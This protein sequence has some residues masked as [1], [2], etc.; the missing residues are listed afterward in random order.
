MI[1]V[2]VSHA[3]SH[4]ESE[5]LGLQL[6]EFGRVHLVL[7]VEA[8]LLLSLELLVHHQQFLWK[9]TSALVVKDVNKL[10]L[11]LLVLGIIFVKEQVSR[12]FFEAAA[13][14]LVQVK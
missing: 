2:D 13:D 7:G 5:L 12:A 3:L 14:V 11:Q 10:L 6:L 8:G 4:Q 1:V 9:D